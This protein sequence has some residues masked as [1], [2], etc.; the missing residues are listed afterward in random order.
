M[1]TGKKTDVGQ[2]PIDEVLLNTFDNQEVRLNNLHLSIIRKVRNYDGRLLRKE[3]DCLQKLGM[4]PVGS[5]WDKSYQTCVTDSVLSQSPPKLDE[6]LR[7]SREANT[8]RDFELLECSKIFS[9]SEIR[10]CKQSVLK[11]L[12][13]VFTKYRDTLPE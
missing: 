13:E 6:Y 1:S 9:E 11:R 7:F 2:L 4:Q 8:R 5:L 12:E 3:F 10:V